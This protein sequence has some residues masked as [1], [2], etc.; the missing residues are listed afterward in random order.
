MSFWYPMYAQPWDATQSELPRL[1][2]EHLDLLDDFNSLG[3]GWDWMLVWKPKHRPSG[4][5]RW[6][7][8]DRKDNTPY[9]GTS[10]YR[11]AVLAPLFETGQLI[12]IS[13]DENMRPLRLVEAGSV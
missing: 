12:A 13:H 1:R 7:L 11:W 9:E 2:P 6:V 5:G 8:F 4:Q 10:G 3:S